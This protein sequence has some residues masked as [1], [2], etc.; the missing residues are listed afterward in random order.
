MEI[1]IHDDFDL[2]RI[3][4]SGQ[5]FRISRLGAGWRVLSGADCLH[6]TP[7]GADRYALDCGEAAFD[8][9]FP[10]KEKLKLPG[11]LV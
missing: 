9:Q 8:A 10:P 3:A 7:L 6:I 2:E 1:E 5:C 4:D 11:Q